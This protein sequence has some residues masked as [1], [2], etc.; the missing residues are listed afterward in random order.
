MA[1]VDEHLVMSENWALQCLLRAPERWVQP[2]EAKTV[3]YLGSGKTGT[4][5]LHYLLS[6]SDRIMSFHE[7]PPRLWHSV[8]LKKEE[9]WAARRDVI[10]NATTYEFMYAETNNRLSYAMH[11]IRLLFP[12]AKYIY[13]LRNLNE[14]VQSGYNW[15]FYHSDDRQREGRLEPPLGL[16]RSQKIA[17]EW[18][19]R[20]KA[21][22]N[23]LET[24]IDEDK[25]F[26]HFNDL[27]SFNTG[28]IQQMFEWL[29]VRPPS[30][31]DINE[32]LR[33]KFNESPNKQ[34][35]EK[36]WHQFD[37]DA[38]DIYRRFA[39]HAKLP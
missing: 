27:R 23:W 25:F 35:V 28:R 5:T 34:P 16:T 33:R 15:G 6:L 30:V 36:D 19:Y 12:F 4:L 13:M 32:V 1:S 18:V 24:E 29:G 38:E 39:E 3:W 31:G 8:T 26:L 14:Y 9:I 21:I 11:A 20:N 7:P 22:L 17:W 2:E 10:S 37:A